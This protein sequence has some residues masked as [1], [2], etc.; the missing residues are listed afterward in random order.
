[1][2]FTRNQW[3]VMNTVYRNEGMR[4]TAIA[5]ATGIG[6]PLGKVIDACRR[7]AGWSSARTRATGVLTGSS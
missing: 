2:G 3:L 6:A 4:Q 1:M 5:E 7:T